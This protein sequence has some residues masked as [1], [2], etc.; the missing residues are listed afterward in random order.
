V[1]NT[2]SNTVTKTIALPAVP[3]AAVCSSARFRVSTASS[4]ES[5][6]VY[7]ANC[8]AGGTS[9]VRTSDDKL[10]NTLPSP[11]TPT[12]GVPQNPVWVMTTQ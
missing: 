5:S 2:G 9:I 6:K 3:A 12:F 7:V 4:P 8:D 1:I 10:V 11:M